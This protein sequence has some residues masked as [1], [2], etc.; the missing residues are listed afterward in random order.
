MIEPTFTGYFRN[1]RTDLDA[2]IFDIDGT[3]SLGKIPLPGARELL[4]E[5]NCSH[6]PYLLLTNDGCNSVEQ[7]AAYLKD[8][9]IP[10]TPRNILSS[11]NALKLWA[12]QH[13]HGG[14]FFQ[15]GK[16]GTPSYADAAGIEEK[17]RAVATAINITINIMKASR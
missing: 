2:V 15:L 5:L 14:K 12:A 8:A 10:V 4:E 9:G 1:H 16:T 11:G 17:R 6:T 13:Y 3:L 7:K